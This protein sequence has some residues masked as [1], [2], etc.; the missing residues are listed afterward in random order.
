MKLVRS[1]SSRLTG[2]PVVE[3]WSVLTHAGNLMPHACGQRVRL[4]SCGIAC[5]ISCGRALVMVAQAQA[6][7]LFH[8]G[9]C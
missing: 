8:R 2:V 1:S 3:S 9:S 4:A 6:K 7:I 5:R